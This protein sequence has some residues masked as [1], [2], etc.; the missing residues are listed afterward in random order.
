MG[1]EKVGTLQL[2]I[3]SVGDRFDS[4]DQQLLDL[5]APQ[6]A[7]VVRA[8][9][10]AESLERARDSVLRAGHAERDRLRRDLHD[11]IGPGLSGASLGLA[12]A[13]DALQVGDTAT[14]GAVL[15]RLR[16]ELAMMALEVRRVIDDLRPPALDHAAG[17]GAALR[18]EYPRTIGRTALTLELREPLPPLGS[19]VETAAYRITRE[20]VTNALRHAGADHVD[21][22]VMSADDALTIEVRDDGHGIED[23][24]RPGVGLNSL[25]HRAETVGGT[26]DIT[27]G[28]TGTVV[29]ARLPVMAHAGGDDE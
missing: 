8:L 2:A 3:R 15:D 29:K 22:L 21:V 18:S 17:L 24:A 4:H 20:S 14:A 23:H 27:S 12:A 5:L 19:D 10:L 6:L 16:Q 13:H 25:H 7:V 9:D 28:P 26:L 11:G 1:G